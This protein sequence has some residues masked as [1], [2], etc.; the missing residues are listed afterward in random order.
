MNRR[1]TWII[2]SVIMFVS[3]G[4]LI[5]Y[6]LWANGYIDPPNTSPTT[7]YDNFTYPSF[8]P[9]KKVEPAS[10][11]ASQET[12]FTEQTAE[13][14][15]VLVDFDL[16]KSI[17]PDVIGWIHMSTPFIS[18]PIMMSP[19]NDNYYLSHNM[20][21]EYD[22]SG[23]LYAEHK[24]NKPDFEDMCTIIYGHRRSDGSMLGNLQSALKKV[25]LSSDPQYIEIYLPD[26]IKIYQICATIPRDKKHILYYNDLS[27]KSVYASFINQVY[28][29]SGSAVDLVK[30]I[31]PEYGDKLLILSTC[32]RTDRSRRFLVI[33]KE[34]ESKPYN[35]D[36]TQ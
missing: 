13:S 32:L 25:N 33:A 1:I 19:T 29:S 21:K 34:I 28:R 14:S 5:F 7:S 24:Y 2:M 22:K 30:D 23:S 4:V 15:D 12:V 26:K 27:K 36:V 31:K 10:T 3:A 11:T 35:T 20:V 16:L 18:Q 6:F 9:S 8:D 17:N